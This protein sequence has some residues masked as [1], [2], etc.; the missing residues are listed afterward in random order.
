MDRYDRQIRVTKIGA[1]GQAKLQAAHVLIVGCGALGTYTAEQCVRM[2][3]GQLTLVDSDHVELHNLQRQTLFTETDALEATPK[4]TAAAKA[5]QAI[6]RAVV[7]NTIQAS[8]EEFLLAELPP[9][10]LLLD[11]T[12]NYQVRQQLNDYCRHYQRPLVFAALAGTTGQVMP[13]RPGVD[14]CL[15][16]AF[17]N[18]TELAQKDCDLLGVMT[19]L[20]PLISSLQVSLALQI[21]TAAPDLRWDQMI[22]VDGWSLAIQKFKVRRNPRCAYCQKA[23][24]AAPNLTIK[25]LCGQ[26]VFAVQMAPALY[27]K[28][29]A[30]PEP[31]TI[32]QNPLATQLTWDH[33]QITCFPN[34]RAHFYGFQDAEEVRP[35]AE[36]LVSGGLFNGHQA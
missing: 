21:L 13:L 25:K 32:R 34:G 5:L 28:L 20:V 36:Q 10:D 31:I 19:P 16:C 35:Y 26:Q 18:L 27:E 30:C 6:N 17:P 23:P 24:A 1:A 12:D 29:A 9:A 33:Y 15:G 11:C 2:G 4:V 22:Y 3:I 8:F 7:I 14:I